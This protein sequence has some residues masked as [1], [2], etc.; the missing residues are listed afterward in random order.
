MRIPFRG[1]E[2]NMKLTIRTDKRIQ[3]IKQLVD[4]TNLFSC[5]VVI[6][7]YTCAGTGTNHTP[8]FFGVPT[9]EQIVEVQEAITHDHKHSTQTHTRYTAP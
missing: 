8:F 3:T 5:R 7:N 1:H 2:N 4:N 6:S 9:K